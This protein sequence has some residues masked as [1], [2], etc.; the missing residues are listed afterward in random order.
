[1]SF[2]QV[3]ATGKKQNKIIEVLAGR[4]LCSTIPTNNNNDRELNIIFSI[5]KHSHQT[6]RG[7]RNHTKSQIR[8]KLII[9]MPIKILISTP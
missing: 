7:L 2:C 9:I 6:D 8:N 4:D 5:G 3:F 1:M